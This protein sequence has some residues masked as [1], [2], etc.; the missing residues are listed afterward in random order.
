MFSPEIAI[1]CGSVFQGYQQIAGSA[2]QV[3][4]LGRRLHIRSCIGQ[5]SVCKKRVKEHDIQAVAA[6]DVVRHKL[7][8]PDDVVPMVFRE[9]KNAIPNFETQ[10][11]DAPPALWATAIRR[12]Q[13][14][15]CQSRRIWS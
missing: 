15:Q 13:Q 8:T 5:R 14:T 1:Q 4:S 7:A 9:F 12:T 10:R 6:D 3:Q 11:R 2:R